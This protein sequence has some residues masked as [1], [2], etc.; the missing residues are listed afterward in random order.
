MVYIPR[1]AEN[2]FKQ[3]LSSPKVLI[4]LGARQV[5]KTTMV[6]H[7]L[8]G[9]KALFLNLDIDIDQ[10]RLM[11]AA[12]LPPAQAINSLGAPSILVIDEAQRLPQA[13]RIVKG[14]Y[15]S[16]MPIK[17]VLLGSS[18]L[19]LLDQSAE[20][21]TGRNEKLLLP[22]LLFEEVVAFQ[23]W[24]S[25]AF[26]REQLES[27]F[28]SQMNTLLLQS[29]VY[30]NYPE[31]VLTADKPG[32]LTNLI[33]DYLL[34]DVLQTNLARTPAALRRL[35]QLLAHQIGSEV[36]VNELANA[37]GISRQTAERYLDLLEETFVIFRLPAFSANPR[38]EITKS[39]KIFFWDT[40]IRNA[41]L[42]EFNFSSLRSD[43]GK[44]WENWVIAEIAKW[45]L[46]IG[47]RKE[48]Y[49]WRSRAGSEVDLVI[50]EG[51]TLRAYEIKWSRQKVRTRAFT[52]H[53]QVPVEVITS[54][55]PLV[56]P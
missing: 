52:E 38:K 9:D 22:P 14:W 36:S 10:Q 32:H 37:L 21:L 45:N 48:L 39:N 17:V 25:S 20:S 4:V 29:M 34:K 18:S 13:S 35:L 42:N 41:L 26:S 27:L 31:T 47:Q 19:D 5:G 50:K 55:H 49:F 33:S 1:I 12:A 15:D 53:Y 2:R 30:G 6:E 24:Y 7:A 3:M 23:P 56:H 44:L 43:I 46:L 16:H 8:S 40:G 51:E 54:E 11:A 28:A